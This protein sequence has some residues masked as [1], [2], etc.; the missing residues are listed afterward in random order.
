MRRLALLAVA[1][2]PALVVAAAVWAAATSVTSGS[3]GRWPSTYF[4]GPLGTNE[5]L[6]ARHGHT[7]LSLW[8]GVVGKTASQ[9]RSFVHQRIT[10]LGRPPDLIGF[11]CDRGCPAG[12][13]TFDT[14]R[15]HLSENWIHSNS[16]VPFV[17]WSPGR[18]YAQIAAGNRDSDIDAAA[19]RFKAFRHRIMVRMFEEFDLHPW[20][21]R[22]FINAWRHVVVRMQSDGATNVGFV[23]CPTEQAAAA[24]KQINASYPGDAYVDWVSS[25]SYNGDTNTSYS[26]THRGWSEFSWMFNYHLTDSPSMEQQWGARK[27]FFVSETSSKYDTAGVPSRHTVDANRKKHWFINIESA[28]A[29]MPHLVGVQFFDA[30]V[31]V[32]EPGNNWRVDSPCDGAG[33]NCTHG[34][35]DANTYSGFLSMADSSQFSGGVAGGN[36]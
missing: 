26:A 30:D 8:S 17:T 4:N 25:D 24:R 28:A 6:P 1:L 11:Q 22:H 36:R 35:S 34:S 2:V 27:P 5:V 14:S 18:S 16:A 21:T 29:N 32:L 13:A 12:S 31:H 10:D 9:E 33:N 3:G 7:L 20:N 15:R 19:R 23:W